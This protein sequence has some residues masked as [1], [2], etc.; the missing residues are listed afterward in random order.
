MIRSHLHEV[1]E[2]LWHPQT[3]REGRHFAHHHHRVLILLHLRRVEQA[4]E[5]GHDADAKAPECP[6]QW[7]CHSRNPR[8][9]AG[10]GDLRT[11]SIDR[12]NTTV[13]RPPRSLPGGVD[14]DASL[15]VL[16]PHV[17]HH[18]LGHETHH[19]EIAN[20]VA[21]DDASEGGQGVRVEHSV[22]HLLCSGAA[23]S[24]VFGL[25]VD[26][27]VDKH[28]RRFATCGSDRFQN[29]SDLWNE[30]NERRAHR[31]STGDSSRRTWRSP[32]PPTGPRRP[33]RGCCGRRPY[34]SKPPCIQWRG[35]S[36][37]SRARNRRLRRSPWRFCTE[38]A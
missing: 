30:R 9:G 14:D 24:Y 20:D 17:F 31:W 25:Y 1:R 33:R 35:A 32:A 28:S 10:V 26:L 13:L 16:S 11:R 15:V 18:P 4:R 29:G 21:F 6:S 27:A 19:V 8:H 23:T 22:D 2:L 3:T 38:V 36:S 37:R 12:G 5:D 34:R 7:Q